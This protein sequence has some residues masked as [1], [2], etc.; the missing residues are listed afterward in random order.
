MFEQKSP[1]IVR[2]FYFQGCSSKSIIATISFHNTSGIL[3]FIFP[4]G[5]TVFEAARVI[6]FKNKVNRD[7]TDNNNS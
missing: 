4:L 1:S 7:L 5:M 6:D 2:G 3:D